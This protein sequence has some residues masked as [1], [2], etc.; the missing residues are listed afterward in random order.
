MPQL[1]EGQPQGL[2]V[3]EV[4]QGAQPGVQVHAHDAA[5]AQAVLGVALR[6][7]VV[8]DGALVGEAPALFVLA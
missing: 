8:V 5:L 4:G 6:G 2:T 3:Q 1:P 7:P